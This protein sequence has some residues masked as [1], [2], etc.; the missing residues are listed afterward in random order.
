MAF[1][2]SVYSMVELLHI[3]LPVI[4]TNKK[5]P[6]TTSSSILFARS[7]RSAHFVYLKKFNEF[8]TIYGLDTTSA[9]NLSSGSNSCVL[10]I[11]ENCY[12]WCPQIGGV[13]EEPMKRDTCI[14]N[15][16]T[17]SRPLFTE[18]IVLQ[19]ADFYSGCHCVVHGI[20]RDYFRRTNFRCSTNH[21]QICISFKIEFVNGGHFISS[22]LHLIRSL[23]RNGNQT[24]VKTHRISNTESQCREEKNIL[25][26]LQ[27]HAS[28]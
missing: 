16:T 13:V 26:N 22:S 10:I 25:D 23:Y 15:T 20:S 4:V 14:E 28:C 18:G 11:I 21:M 12:A 17:L 6:S 1:D 5:K 7:F 19:P 8:E 2:K 27:K 24:N 9:R 3:H